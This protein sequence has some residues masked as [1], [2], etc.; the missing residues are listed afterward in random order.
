MHA[1]DCRPAC[2]EFRTNRCEQG[3]RYRVG[4][5]WSHADAYVRTVRTMSRRLLAGAP[6]VALRIG[7]AEA[8]QLVEHVSAHAFVP[9]KRHRH[10]R[11]ADI[12]DKARS[13]CASETNGGTRSVENPWIGRIRKSA[14]QRHQSA[15][16]VDERI[17]G[18]D[19]PVEVRE[20]E[21]GVR[22]DQGG[23]DRDSSETHRVATR[24]RTDA[25]YPAVGDAHPAVADRAVRNR[26][27]PFC[28]VG[29]H[30]QVKGQR[31]RVKWHVEFDL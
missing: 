5:V 26:K 20:L 14:P 16:P 12:T 29:P 1:R 31:S 30:G 9:E 28:S 17:T 27:N 8:E 13:G 3:G 4:S 18:W 7:S 19:L 23:K 15:N 6:H 2:I 21:M 24:I 22:V 10:E 25:T 11:V